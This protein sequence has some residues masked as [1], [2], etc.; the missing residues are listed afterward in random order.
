MP[1]HEAEFKVN[2]KGNWYRSA[3]G[4][5]CHR[6]DAWNADAAKVPLYHP[7]TGQPVTPEEHRA[8]AVDKSA[9]DRN[10]A[11]KFLAGGTAAVSMAALAGAMQCGRELGL[12]GVNLTEE[13]AA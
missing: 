3:S 6:V 1:P 12:V 7:E 13:V 9:W 4:M 8:L 5:M 11:L 2:A 10:H